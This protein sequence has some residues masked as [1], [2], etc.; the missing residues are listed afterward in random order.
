VVRDVDRQAYLVTEVHADI[1]P[2]DN[3]V[4]HQLA[5]VLAALAH[6]LS[7]PLTAIHNYVDGAQR[8]LQRGRPDLDAVRQALA[9][10]SGQIRRGTDGV[11]L[12]RD[13][14]NEMRGTR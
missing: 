5:D 9:Q 1:A 14:A 13:T 8:L 6:E 12:L 2:E 3:G 7:E 11:N 10:A 4:C